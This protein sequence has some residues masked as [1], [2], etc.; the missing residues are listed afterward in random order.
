MAAGDGVGCVL[1]I[2]LSAGDIN[3]VIEK[4]AGAASHIRGNLQG[5]IVKCIGS[6]KIEAGIYL[7]GT[8]VESTGLAGTAVHG[9]GYAR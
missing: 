7:H 5:R 8:A 3:A 4:G 2:Q 9:Q 1:E 6:I